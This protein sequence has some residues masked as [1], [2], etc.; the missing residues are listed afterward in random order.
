MCRKIISN[1]NAYCTKEMILL[2]LALF[3]LELQDAKYY[4][5]VINSHIAVVLLLDNVGQYLQWN[6]ESQ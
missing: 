4:Q 1:A 3:I 5:S 6:V 2:F